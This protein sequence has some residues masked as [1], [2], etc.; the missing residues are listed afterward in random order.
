MTRRFDGRVALVTGASRGIGEAIARRLAAEGASVVV[1]ASPRSEPALVAVADAIRRAGGIAVPLVADLTDERLVETL[2]AAAGRSFGPVDMLINNAAGISA[3]APPGAIDA[4][5]R[6]QMM[7]LNLEAPVALCQQVLPGMHAQ[8][9]GR[10]LNIGS[11]MARQPS[12]PYP[13]PARFVHALG[14][15]GVT[16]ADLHRYTEALAA[17]LSG[18]GVTANVLLP[19]KIVATEAA[20]AVVAQAAARNPDWIEPVEVMAE[21]AAWLLASTVTGQLA[22][23]RNLLHQMQAGV[24]ALDGGA[25]LGDALLP[26]MTRGE[27]P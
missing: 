6:R 24:H 9:W 20:A 7:M 5:A 23:S 10:I 12:V 13:G 1:H 15:Y 25:R 18:S 14:Y 8:G 16:K 22:V 2:A 4:P 26:Y 11:E 21:A 3:Y 19:Y 27:T 17:E